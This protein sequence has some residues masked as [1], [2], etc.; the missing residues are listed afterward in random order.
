MKFT[1]EQLK[2]ITHAADAA[3]HIV[4]AED[5]IEIKMRN[6]IVVTVA[7]PWGGGHREATVEILVRT[8]YEAK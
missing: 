7:S 5:P 3:A 4:S 6:G 8:L 1:I 2:A